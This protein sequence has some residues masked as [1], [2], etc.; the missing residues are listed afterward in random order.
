MECQQDAAA[1]AP[2]II[3]SP[4][5]IKNVMGFIQGYYEFSRKLPARE[6]GVAMKKIPLK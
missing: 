5:I 1:A 6:P 4:T 2:I 3:V